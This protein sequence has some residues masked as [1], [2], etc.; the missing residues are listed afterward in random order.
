MEIPIKLP[1][2]DEENVIVNLINNIIIKA[3]RH[4]NLDVEQAALNYEVCKIYGLTEK[5]IEIV[6]SYEQ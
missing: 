4:E 1:S 5:E 6:A 3:K 2:I